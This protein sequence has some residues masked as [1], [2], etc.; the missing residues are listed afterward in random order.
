MRVDDLR[1]MERASQGIWAIA[2][3]VGNGVNEPEATGAEPLDT[4]VTSNLIG[5]VESLCDYL[6][7]FV[8]AAIDELPPHLMQSDAA[9]TPVSQMSS[10]RV[11]I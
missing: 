1:K 11:G 8:S 5:A 6:G 2:R 9:M 7:R 10:D 3:I 4:W